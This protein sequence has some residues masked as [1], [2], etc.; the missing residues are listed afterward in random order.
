[1]I[2]NEEIMKR[3]NKVLDVVEKYLKIKDWIL[4][5]WQLEKVEKFFV[6]DCD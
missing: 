5:N 4:A 3:A 6:S 1:M 2:L